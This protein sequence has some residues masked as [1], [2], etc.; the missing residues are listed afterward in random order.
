VCVCQL[1]L[2]NEQRD[3]RGCTVDFERPTEAIRKNDYIHSSAA[4]RA[5]RISRK[6][7]VGWFKTLYSRGYK[8]YT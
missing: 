5:Q 3:T 4:E 6:D 2:S 7:T 1:D 8:H